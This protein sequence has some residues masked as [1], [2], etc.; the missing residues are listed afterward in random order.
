MSTTRPS[1]HQV[2]RLAFSQATQ[3]L[4]SYALSSTSYPHHFFG[5]S[6]CQRTCS[7]NDKP[8]GI[9]S[10]GGFADRWFVSLNLHFAFF[11]MCPVPQNFFSRAPSFFCLTPF[12]H[13]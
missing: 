5:W 9:C 13:S 1:Q 8:L 10:C 7:L 2:I 12:F 3:N 4:P 6:I 11:Y